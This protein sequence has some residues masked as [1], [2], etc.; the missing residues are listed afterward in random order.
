M[1]ELNC[2]VWKC[3]EGYVKCRDGEQCIKASH[4]CDGFRAHCAD[5]SD[6]DG[7]ICREWECPDGKIRPNLVRILTRFGEQPIG[8]RRF[9]PFYLFIGLPGP[10]FQ[11]IESC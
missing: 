2:G 4:M 5:R 11:V 8:L 7:E 3:G 1:D 10:A 6:E 9:Y